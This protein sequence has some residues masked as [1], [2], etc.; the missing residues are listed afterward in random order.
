MACASVQDISFPCSNM[1]AFLSLYFPFVELP[2]AQQYGQEDGWALQKLHV[3]LSEE[4]F[5]AR[6]NK[7]GLIWVVSE[8]LLLSHLINF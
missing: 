7:D 2:C 8:S 5:T 4:A 6:Q 1:A 3:L